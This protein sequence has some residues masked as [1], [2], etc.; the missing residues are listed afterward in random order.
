MIWKF[1]V[2]AST[3]LIQWREVT[4]AAK[5]NILLIVMDDLGWND[6]SYKGSDIPTPTIDKLANEGVRL[7]QYYVQRLCSPTRSAILTG[8]YPYHNGLADGV[9]LAGHPYGLPLNQTTVANE[10][11]RGGYAT[12]M[13]GKWHLGMCMYVYVGVHPNLQGI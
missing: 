5:P 11:K 13:V 12:H 8:R 2:F 9:I 4:A 7:Q 6:T 1:L 3:I 10:L